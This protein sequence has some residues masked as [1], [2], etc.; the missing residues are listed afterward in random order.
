MDERAELCHNMFSI[1]VGV[2]DSLYGMVLEGGKATRNRQRVRRLRYRGI[3]R[4]C[5]NPSPTCGRG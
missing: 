2:P 1:R 3:R 5:V 4:G